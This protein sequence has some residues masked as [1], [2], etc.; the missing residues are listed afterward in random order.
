MPVAHCL[1]SLAWPLAKTTQTAAW[2]SL[3]KPP[4]IPQGSENIPAQTGWVPDTRSHQ[5]LLGAFLKC[6]TLRELE[7][8]RS[9]RGTKNRDDGVTWNLKAGGL[10]SCS[11]ARLHP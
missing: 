5:V 4:E 8:F 2:D 7:P 3:T 11:G 6:A 10:D 9:S 1:A